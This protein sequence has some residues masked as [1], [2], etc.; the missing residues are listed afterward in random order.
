[1]TLAMFRVMALELWRD[2]G[3]LVMA[4]FLPPLVFLIFSAV[5]SGTTG[6]NIKLR[7]AIAD[8]AHTETS[9]RLMAAMQADP[10]VITTSRNRVGRR[11]SVSDRH[12]ACSRCRPE[13]ARTLP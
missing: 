2:R 11:R 7:V 6:E 10:I 5:F 12:H 4:F 1:M 9:R 3:A 8:V 13:P